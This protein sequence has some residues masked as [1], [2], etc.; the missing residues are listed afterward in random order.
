MERDRRRRGGHVGEREDLLAPRGI[1]EYLPLEPVE[2][3][4]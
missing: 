4:R 1:E 2:K 3:I